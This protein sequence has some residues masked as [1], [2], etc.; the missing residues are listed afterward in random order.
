MWKCDNFAIH[1]STFLLLNVEKILFLIFIIYCSKYLARPHPRSNDPSPSK[2]MFRWPH[3][4]SNNVRPYQNS[5]HQIPLMDYIQVTT[6]TSKWPNYFQMTTPT[7]ND[8]PTF[9][10][11]HPLPN[12][13]PTFKWPHP[14]S[15]DYIP[16]KINTY[17]RMRAAVAWQQSHGTS[18]PPYGHVWSGAAVLQLYC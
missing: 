18:F 9:K 6:P 1:Y 4:L 14:L 2:A 12:D 7:P 5:N 13:P 17:L 11:P 10:W 3:P 8:P 16:L 15:N